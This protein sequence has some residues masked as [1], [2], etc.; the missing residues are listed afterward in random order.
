MRVS[1]T[2]SAN[3]QKIENELTDVKAVFHNYKDGIYSFTVSKCPKNEIQDFILKS[4]N[5]HKEG[6]VVKYK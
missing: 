2:T 3:I 1:A 6:F 4:C 5:P